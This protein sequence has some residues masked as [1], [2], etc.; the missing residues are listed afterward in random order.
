MF[1]VWDIFEIAVMYSF[2]PETNER[3]LEE[4]VEGIVASNPVEKILQK[5]VESAV[6][7]I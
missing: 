6:L 4:L 1:I 7:N 2:F 3:I 5:R